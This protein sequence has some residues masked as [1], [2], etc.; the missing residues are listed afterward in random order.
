VTDKSSTAEPFLPDR[1]S[2]TALRAA[3]AT[4]R[5]CDLWERATQSVFGEG[6]A[7]AE[8]VL[9][10]E[11]PGD[12]EDREGH[13]FVGPAGRILDE[14]LER[15]GIARERAY[16]TNAVKH[17]SWEERG[18]RRIHQTPSRWEIVACGPWLAA[19]LTAVRPQVLVLMGRVA[20]T[21]VMGSAFR[22]TR[23]R[24]RVL[25]GPEGLPTVATVHPSAILRGPP[26]DREAA[27]AAFAS[28]LEVARSVLDA[29]AA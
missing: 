6:P 12:H 15:A 23:E 7:R 26:S 3:A 4:C 5:G 28:D 21:S 29:S 22:V 8:I 9:V 14:G 16:V 20:A 2:L 1:R 10:G 27:L 19:E 13:P 25:E 17:F 18:K 24:G 11:A